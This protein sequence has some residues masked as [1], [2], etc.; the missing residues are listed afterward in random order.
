MAAKVIVSSIEIFQWN[1][2][3]VRCTWADG[4]DKEEFDIIDVP[5]DL[6]APQTTRNQVESNLTDKVNVLLQQRG[7]ATVNPSAMEYLI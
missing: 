3:R 5:I 6:E 2:A 7:R 1:Y 4:A